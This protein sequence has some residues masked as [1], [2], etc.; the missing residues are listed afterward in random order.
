MTVFDP[1]RS[2]RVIAP[3]AEMRRE[4]T[5]VYRPKADVLNV[6][7]G[8]KADIGGYGLGGTH[9]PYLSASL[10]RPMMSMSPPP[11]ERIGAVKVAEFSSPPGVKSLG[12]GL[13]SG[14]D[15]TIRPIA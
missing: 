1:S 11:K 14:P 2:W 15:I 7:F 4:L 13:Q 12:M 10:R 5:L 9:W 6:C 8:G 3:K